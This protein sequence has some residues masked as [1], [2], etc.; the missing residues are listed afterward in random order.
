MPDVPRRHRRLLAT[1]G[2]P[3]VIGLLV[4]AWVIR[5]FS[6]GPV[7]YDSA[8]SVIHFDRIVSGQHLEAFV[9]AT[10]KPLL[11]VMYGLVHAVVPDWRAISWLAI[12]GLAVA[13]G[14]ASLLGDR[15]SGPVAAGFATMGVLGSGPLLIDVAR[16]YAVVWALIG[17]LIAGLALTGP[18]RHYALAGSALLLASLARLETLVLVPI[19]VVLLVGDRVAA[20]DRRS[21]LPAGAWWLLLP[22]AA[23]PIM[24]VHDQLLTGNPW[25]WTTVAQHYS[26]ANPAAVRT[27]IQVAG[28]LISHSRIQ[29]AISLLGFVGI[30]VMLRERRWPIAAGLLG[31]SLGTAVFLMV[32]AARGIYVSPRY[33]TSID[34]ALIMAAAI[35]VGRLRIPSLWRVSIRRAVSP[36][37]TLGMLAIVGA[38]IA[39]ALSAPFGPLD[40]RTRTVIRRERV[41]TEHADAALATLDHWLD[42]TPGSRS[43]S[44]DVS[45]GARPATGHPSLLVPALMQPRMALDLDVPLSN[46]AGLTP[47]HATPG[48]LLQPGQI[49]FHDRRGDAPADGYLALELDRPSDLGEL[50]LEPLVSRSADR[51]WVLAT[52]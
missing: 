23:V 51:W 49:I 25:F 40:G 12:G 8:A 44:G 22:I 35:G 6:A 47:D 11:T 7:D 16:S 48:G 45:L 30:A 37:F 13:L 9:T 43:S 20:R 33:I 46:I 34:L 17:W 36:A 38:T 19:A 52:R 31:L 42:A 39:V 27:P 1:F 24:L 32:L 4:G 28:N 29:A 14:L 41:L 3:V 50:T 5:P 15:L 18:R 10:P 26:D 21:P 2:I